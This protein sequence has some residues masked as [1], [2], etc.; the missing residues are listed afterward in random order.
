MKEGEVEESEIED[1]NAGCTSAGRETWRGTRD[2]M[3]KCFGHTIQL[4]PR[5]SV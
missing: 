2:G 3:R 4:E 5:V 1:Q